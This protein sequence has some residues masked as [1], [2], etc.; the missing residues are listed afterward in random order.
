MTQSSGHEL[1]DRFLDHLS[2]VRNMS[3]HTVR[4]YAADMRQFLDWCERNSYDPLTLKHRQLRGYLAELDLARYERRTIARKTSTLRSFYVFLQTQGLA[5]VNPAAVLGTPR[6]QRRLPE[7]VPS[8]LMTALLEAPDLS[9]PK[10]LRDA[11]ILELLYATGIRVGELETL[12]VADVDLTQG[13]VK[14]MGK[15]S[16]ERIVPMHR[17]AVNRLRSYL[18]EGRPTYAQK[19]HTDALFLNRLGTRLQSGSVRRLLTS[20]LDQL[21]ADRGM[22]PHTLRHTFATHLLE[23]GADLRS[24][25]ELLGHVALSTTQIYT[26]LGTKRLK[27]VH[28]NAHPRA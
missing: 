18:A 28:R 12:D 27:D 14:V 10:G 3:P 4:A 22:H 15:G 24:V 8:D 23:G 19:S 7:T 5:D 16:K 25:Q 26:H 1:A 17:Q 2:V 13:Q 20:Y 6:L 9:K 21:G 11:A